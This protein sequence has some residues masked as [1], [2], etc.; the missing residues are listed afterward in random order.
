MQCSRPGLVQLLVGW[1][2]HSTQVEATPMHWLPAQ[3]SHHQPGAAKGIGCPL[4]RAIT[5]LVRPR[6]AGVQVKHAA[7]VVE[8]CPT[9][10]VWPLHPPAPLARG[11]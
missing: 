8:G 7:S 9:I 3:K 5:S 1:L 6:A 2:T 4:K 10:K 11:A